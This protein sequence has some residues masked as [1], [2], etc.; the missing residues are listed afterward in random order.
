MITIINYGMGNLRSVQKG[1][2]KVGAQALIT[3]NPDE[4]LKAD[5]IVLPGVGAFKQAMESLSNLGLIDPL[6]SVIKRGVP[7]LGICLG[8]QL[9][10]SESEEFGNC[11]GLG[12]IKGKI[13]KFNNSQ[14][15]T[16]K[17]PHMGWNSINILK[18]S[19]LYNSI[20]NNTF[21][22]FVHSYYAEPADKD[23]ILS[24]SEYGI[25]FT[26][27]IA[28]DNIFATQF[29]PEKSQIEGLKILKNFAEI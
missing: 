21:F 12:L 18:D 7:Y 2:E 3:N 13:K 14:D 4:I 23:N 11:R 27:A 15:K 5:K 17:I 6:I 24:S 16:L 20:K 28:V 22:Y 9:L 1:F 19:P 29:H 10:F 25:N 8:L 26:S